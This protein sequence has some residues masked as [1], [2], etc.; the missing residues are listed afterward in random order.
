MKRATYNVLFLVRKTKKRKNGLY[1]IH[2]RLTVNG[3][4]AEFV[5]Q[6]EV[7]YDEWDNHRECV[8]GN[9]KKAREINNY[10]DLVKSKLMEQKVIMQEK[11]EAVTAVKLKDCYLGVNSN[12]TSL[13]ELYDEHNKKCMGLVNKDF[14]PATIQKHITTRKHL[15]EF[16][17]LKYKKKDLELNEI[18]P[19]FVEDFEYHMKVERNCGNNTT[20]KHMKNLKKIFRIAIENNYIKNSP[21][22]N[23]KIQM[24]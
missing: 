8:K 21:F 13:L 15:S 19:S 17:Q 20:V 2:C 23:K 22:V 3:K 12:Q 16:M 7:P 24:G 6:Q 5:I 14:A 4:R 11:N 9:S 10:L 1:P 18:T